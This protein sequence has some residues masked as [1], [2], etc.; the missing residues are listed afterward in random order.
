MVKHAGQ[1]RSC[2]V[3]VVE[4]SPRHSKEGR[5]H[6]TSRIARGTSTARGT[7]GEKGNHRSQTSMFIMTSTSAAACNTDEF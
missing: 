4:F 6:L 2:R 1:H 3:D 7:G 5:N